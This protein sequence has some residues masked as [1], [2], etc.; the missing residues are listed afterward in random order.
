[1]AKVRNYYKVL[2]VSRDATED[3]IKLAF[4]N[5]AKQ[6]QDGSTSGAQ[7]LVEAYEVLANGKKRAQ[8]DRYLDGLLTT[9]QL[10]SDLPPGAV[11]K[12]TAPLAPTPQ[13]ALEYT[14]E[15]AR[16][17]PMD[18]GVYWEYLTLETSH[19]YGTTKYYIDGEMIPD[20]RNA[21][22]ADVINH[23]G[24]E[25]WEMVGIGQGVDRAIYIFKRQTATPRLMGNKPAS[26]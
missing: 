19:N 13:S 9:G 10:A 3:Q 8:Y 14:P 20:L 2:G 24:G 26:A 12:V 4:H 1:M 17:Q 25:S 18:T 7:M 11:E 21:Q 15:P 23:L 16:S 6:Y 5:Q 22:F